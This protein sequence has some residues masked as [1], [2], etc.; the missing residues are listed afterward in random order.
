MR[1][2]AA[3]GLL[4]LVV[5]ASVLYGIMPVWSYYS[6]KVV[7]VGLQSHQIHRYEYL[8]A[9]E[10]S[11]DGALE[12]IELEN[13]GGDLFLAGNKPAIA[14]ANMREFVTEAVQQ[15]GGQLISSQDY[16][17]KSIPETTAV[18]LQL[19][20]SG[21]VKQLVE[22]VHALETTRPVIFIDEITIHSSSSRVRSAR[23]R[24]SKK[25]PPEKNSL[26]I[27]L[28]IVGYLAGSSAEDPMGDSENGS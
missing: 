4:L 8:L 14:S 9:N 28:N 15:S 11:I 7:E 12:Q 21:E 25:P 2:F 24:R 26:D 16:K 20:V 10:K 23:S 5:L 3:V 13:V 1:R 27:T 22:L 17:P 19:H 18:G 6:G